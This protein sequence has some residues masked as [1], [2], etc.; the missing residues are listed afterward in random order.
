MKRLNDQLMAIQAN[1]QLLGRPLLLV[2]QG[3][4]REESSP[5]SFALVAHPGLVSALPSRWSTMILAG[6]CQI[7]LIFSGFF[8]HQD[9][10]CLLKEL[11][12]SSGIN[13]NMKISKNK[14]H[15]VR[16][17]LGLWLNRINSMTAFPVTN[18]LS[19]SFTSKCPFKKSRPIVWGWRVLGERGN[20]K[21]SIVCQNKGQLGLKILALQGQWYPGLV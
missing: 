6:S 4:W 13:R 11:F 5:G 3:L 17:S 14:K 2:C 15:L 18:Y 1:V 12:W 20:V 9:P 7:R 10:D 16:I 21:L 19:S 8:Q